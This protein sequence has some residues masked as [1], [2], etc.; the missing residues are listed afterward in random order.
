MGSGGGRTVDGA[1]DM[2]SACFLL[3]E[4]TKVDQT[5]NRM[6]FILS[7]TSKGKLL[8]QS[9]KSMVRAAAPICLG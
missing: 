7:K 1:V 6:G 3:L 9:E 4:R 2:L 8:V 5:E